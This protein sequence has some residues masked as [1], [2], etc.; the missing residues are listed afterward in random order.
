MKYGV[1]KK[2]DLLEDLRRWETLLCSSF[3]MRPVEKLQKDDDVNVAQYN[4]LRSASALAALMTQN[5]ESEIDYYRKIVTIPKYRSISWFQLTEKEKSVQ[6]VTD[7]LE[8][9][10]EIYQ[11][12][13]ESN[14]K[15]SFSIV[16][17]VFQRDESNSVTKFL[18]SNVNDNFHQNLYSLSP[19]KYDQEK[20][21]HKK[22]LTQKELL[23]IIDEKILELPEEEFQ[24]RI[25]RSLDKI[26]LSHRN[27]QIFLILMSGPFLIGFYVFKYALKILVFYFLLRKKKK[28]DDKGKKGK[29]IKKE[30]NQTRQETMVSKESAT[31]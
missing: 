10:R 25:H 16:D 13:M 2:K 22:A 20:R 7:K 21:F 6:V 5:G 26:L 9:F 14:F 31:S 8:Q 29:E 1:I 3:L 28:P 15:N 18:L 4:N 19:L 11:P 23:E 24:T 12:I 17:G 30:D 27:S